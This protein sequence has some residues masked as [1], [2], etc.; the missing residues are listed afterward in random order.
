MILILLITTMTM[1]AVM[2]MMTMMTMIT[3]LTIRPMMTLMI[4]RKDNDDNADFT[5]DRR[6]CIHSPSTLAQ[7]RPTR[8]WERLIIALVAIIGIITVTM[9]K[10]DM[11]AKKN[12][13]WCLS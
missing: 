13:P 10:N 4:M 9:I 2:T 8:P 7:G 6:A 3:M 5:D 11:F 12:S 1:G